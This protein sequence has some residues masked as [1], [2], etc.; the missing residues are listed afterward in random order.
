MLVYGQTDVEKFWL[1]MFRDLV[2]LVS[3]YI[4]RLLLKTLR[5]RCF[6]NL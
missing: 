6:M 2:L 4:A 5:S 3:I 1:E